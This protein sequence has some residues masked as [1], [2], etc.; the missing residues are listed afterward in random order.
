MPSI[1]QTIGPL[2]GITALI[3]LPMLSNKGERSPKRRPWAVVVVV[4][5]VV[6]VTSLLV[7]G[8][9]APWSPRSE[10]KP[11]AQVQA[12]L[13]DLVLALGMSLFYQKGCQY[14]HRMQG[15]GGHTG[16]ELSTIV[17][18]WTEQQLQTQIVNGG[19]DMPAYGGMLTKEELHAL[20][21]YLK[22]QQ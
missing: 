3:A 9:Q 17:R 8:F 7:V 19:S 11:I 22:A 13:Q 10:T 14:C 20:V 16:P 15:G 2:P 4:C 12:K 21:A 6:F 5:V 18:S 1:W